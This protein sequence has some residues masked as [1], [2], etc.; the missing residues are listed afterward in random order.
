MGKWIDRLRADTAE[1]TRRADVLARLLLWGWPRDEAEAT[2]ARIARRDADDDRRT[3]VEC[4]HYAPGR[5]R[6]HRR[7]D[8]RSPDVG[9]ALAALPQRCGGFGRRDA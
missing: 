3:C 6:N 2:A 5:C 9:R 1:A 4:R 8:L 7:T